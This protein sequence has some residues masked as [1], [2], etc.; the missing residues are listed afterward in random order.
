MMSGLT[1]SSTSANLSGTISPANPAPKQAQI[2]WNAINVQDLVSYATADQ[3]QGE[4][5][6]QA[7]NTSG[8]TTPEEIIR[9]PRTTTHRLRLTPE[10]IIHRRR[11][12]IHRTTIRHHRLRSPHGC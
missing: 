6:K 11:T 7:N 3:I 10:A 1:N 8:P 9:R 5:L 4:L 2:L 12:T